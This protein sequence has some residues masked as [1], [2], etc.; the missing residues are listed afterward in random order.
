MVFLVVKVI[1]NLHA[2]PGG[3][4]IVAVCHVEESETCIALSLEVVDPC[5]FLL[6]AQV[7]PP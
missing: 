1:W 7:C 3:R 2:F 5:P 4:R 6:E